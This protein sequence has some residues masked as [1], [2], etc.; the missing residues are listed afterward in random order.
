M[1]IAAQR[2]ELVYGLQAGDC[3]G[4]AAEQAQE[5]GE[6]LGKQVGPV[7]QVEEGHTP[8]A[9]GSM[10]ADSQQGGGGKGGGEKGVEF[11]RPAWSPH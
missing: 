2:G 5:E 8:G 11:T 10:V 7:G 3:E 1:Q 4:L 6:F 9:Q